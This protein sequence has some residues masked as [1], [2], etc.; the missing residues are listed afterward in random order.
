MNESLRRSRSPPSNSKPGSHRQWEDDAQLLT[1]DES[2]YVD[3]GGDDCYIRV[4]E[5]I[6]KINGCHLLWGDALV[7]TDMFS[8]P[9]GDHP[10]QGLGESDPIVLAGDS[11]E[12]L[13]AFLSI[14]YA[15]Y[16]RSS[17]F[18]G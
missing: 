16:V 17:I 13:R 5:I 14:A 12:T 11:S 1:L 4:E 2:F 10:I 6:F 3:N 7:F 15:E 18:L 8:L 9:S